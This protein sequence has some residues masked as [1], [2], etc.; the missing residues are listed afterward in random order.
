MAIAGGQSEG[1]TRGDRAFHRVIQ[2]DTGASAEAHIGNG[3]LGGIFGYPVHPGGDTAHRT[4]SG[5]VQDAY[6]NQVDSLGD[7]I[8]GTADRTRDMGSVPVAVAAVTTPNVEAGRCAAS[9]LA[10]T[11][12]D[13]GIDDV[14]GNT[15]SSGSIAVVTV[16][17]QKM[18]ID[19]VQSPCSLALDSRN[20]YG[21]R[22]D[23]LD[24]AIL[25]DI[26]HMRIARQGLGTGLAH[27]YHASVEDLP[28]DPR[29][30]TVLAGR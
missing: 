10:V 2:R 9:E 13:S 22:H 12:P 1:H 3:G 17:R 11:E 24:D 14:G 4:R 25:L 29:N 7:A 16:E 27:L 28:V 18:L 5:A 15:R 30:P 19:T 21:G 20:G 6:G 23:H 8:R 26:G